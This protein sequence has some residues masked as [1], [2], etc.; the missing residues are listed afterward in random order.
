MELQGLNENGLPIYSQ[1][2][3]KFTFV[4]VTIWNSDSAYLESVLKKSI[5]TS[6]DMLRI[7]NNQLFLILSKRPE[8]NHSIEVIQ[9]L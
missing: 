5:L 6:S 8:G 3:F 9:I 1:M 2:K 7:I 4:S